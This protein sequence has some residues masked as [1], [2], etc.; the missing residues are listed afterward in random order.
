MNLNFLARFKDFVDKNLNEYIKWVILIG[1]YG[2]YRMMAAVI[3]PS[4]IMFLIVP[5]IVLSFLVFT[6]DWIL[7]SLVAM[8]SPR[9]GV[10]PALKRPGTLVT[11]SLAIGLV[12]I[13]IFYITEYI[14]FFNLG[15]FGLISSS[16]VIFWEK[17]NPY[18]YLSLLLFAIGLIGL[19]FSFVQNSGVPLASVFFFLG[20]T[21][22][23]FFKLYKNRIKKTPS[24]L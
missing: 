10:T 21:A 4:R 1:L 19:V 17:N 16:L 9:S 12:G 23:Y 7:D 15:F 22:F 11:I 24:P 14:P 5:L 3:E 6:I 8:V 13:I 18:F 20:F 2:F